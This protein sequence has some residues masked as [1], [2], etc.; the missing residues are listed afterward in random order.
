MRFEVSDEPRFA[1]LHQVTEVR[2]DTWTS[3][4]VNGKKFKSPVIV[5]ILLTEW[6][7][8]YLTKSLKSVF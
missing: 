3:G 6:K 1:R 4:L 5:K 7:T 2:S 8:E